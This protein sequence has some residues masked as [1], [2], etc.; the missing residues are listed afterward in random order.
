MSTGA[1]YGYSQQPSYGMGGMGGYGG[2]YGS[3]NPYQTGGMG[4]YSGQYN[5]FG[6]SNYGMSNPYAQMGF[7]GDYSTGYTDPFGSSFSNPFSG[8]YGTSFGGRGMGG[9]MGGYNQFGGYGQVGLGYLPPQQPTINDTV[10]NQFMQQ[11]YGGAFGLGGQPQPRRQSPRNPFRSQPSVVNPM[12]SEYA[13]PTNQVGPVTGGPGL[14]P[15]RLEPSPAAA[16]RGVAS[17][18]INNPAYQQQ[19]AASNM[20]DYQRLMQRKNSASAG[21]YVNPLTGEVGGVNPLAQVSDLEIANSLGYKDPSADMVPDIRSRMPFDANLGLQG[22]RQQMA[23][24]GTLGQSSQ[25][26]KAKEYLNSIGYGQAGFDA[27]K[28]EVKRQ[29]VSTGIGLGSLMS[30][31]SGANNSYGQLPVRPLALWDA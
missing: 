3:Y 26:E 15:P 8:G 27:S 22:L 24:A 16:T 12:P 21:P 23:A 9:G 10:A 19:M 28:Y 13:G 6:M 30:G 31:L 2:M 14:G 29:P 5:P 1:S 18:N 17:D 4:G 25:N 11:Y 20:T 7:G